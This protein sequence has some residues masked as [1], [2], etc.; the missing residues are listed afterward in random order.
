MLF[1][2]L[3]FNNSHFQKNHQSFDVFQLMEKA[4]MYHKDAA[5]LY[6]ALSLGIL[7]EKKLTSIIEHKMFDIGFSQ[8]RLSLLQD[9]DLWKKS[10]RIDSYGDELFKLKNR[11]GQEFCLSATAEEIITQIYF[12]YYAN[13]HADM[14]V[15]QIGNKYRDELRARAGLV[16][17]KEFIMKDGY[18]FHSSQKD[19]LV[20]YDLVS[21]A[22]QEIFHQLGLQFEIKDSDVGEIGGKYSQEFLVKSTLE[23]HGLLE[24]AHIFQLG[25]TYSEKFNLKNE[26]NEF[27]EM[28]CYGIGISR[29]LMTLLEKQRDNYGFF[30]T[31]DFHT[32][33]YIITAIDYDRN[34]EVRNMAF[35]LYQLMKSK[36]ISVLLDD[37]AGLQAGK[38][39]VDS[40]LIGV[41]NRIVISQKSIEK[42]QFELTHRMNMEKYYSTSVESFMRGK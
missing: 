37:R 42:N 30:G 26:K 27:I 8:C 17:A 32:F 7:L 18:S 14:N 4:C 36:N 10:Q 35:N 2:R 39:L 12:D 31:H 28:N 1:S 25:T 13:Q 15:F 24:I 40:E 33:E 21:Q 22:Y 19:S 5:G 6:S 34:E 20:Q 9:T 29:L 23:D 11:K 16:R 3:F 38:K 41:E